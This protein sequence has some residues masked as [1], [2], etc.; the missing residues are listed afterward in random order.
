[1]CFTWRLS[2]SNRLLAGKGKA[3]NKRSSPQGKKKLSGPSRG[4]YQGNLWTER[5]GRPSHIGREVA[6]SWPC[7][8]EDPRVCSIPHITGIWSGTQH[9]RQCCTLALLDQYI[10]RPDLGHAHRQGFGLLM[11]LNELIFPG[12]LSSSREKKSINYERTVTGIP[13]WP[14]TLELSPG[15]LGLFWLCD[16]NVLA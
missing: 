5:A 11:W 12:C 15:R 8:C 6:W 9:I 7:A 10:I 4:G 1:M 3:I 2:T 13:H 14:N 16:C